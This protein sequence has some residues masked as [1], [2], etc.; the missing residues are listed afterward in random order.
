MKEKQT[1]KNKIGYSFWGIISSCVGIVIGTGIFFKSESVINSAGPL[2]S[3]VAWIL[4]SVIVVCMGMS[5]IEIASSTSKTGEVGS[6]HTWSKKFFNVKI[7]KIIGIFITFIWFPTLMVLISAIS[8]DFIMQSI[9]F[10]N[11]DIVNGTWERFAF[12]FF[13]SFSLICTMFALNIF[14]SKW[15]EKF[16]II[17]VGI[18][19]IPFFLIV[20]IGFFM[21]ISGTLSGGVKI[22]DNPK[23]IDN[24]GLQLNG[25]FLA[26]PAILF[27]FDG[28]IY[29][30]NLQNEMKDK[31]KFPKAMVVSMVIISVTYLGVSIMSVLIGPKID[32]DG[33]HIYSVPAVLDVMFGGQAWIS[34]II[35]L[36]IAISGINGING[37][38]MVSMQQLRSLSESELIC[39]KKESFQ[40]TDKKGIPKKSAFYMFIT[41]LIWFIILWTI[42]IIRYFSSDILSS[43]KYKW[44]KTI[45]LIVVANV[46]FGYF[47]YAFIILG[48]IRNRKTNKIKVDKNKWFLPVAWI[49]SIGVIFFG[50]YNIIAIFVNC[51]VSYK[52]PNFNQLGS[53]ITTIALLL[54][55]PLMF[56]LYTINEKIFAKHNNTIK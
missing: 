45:D 11:P 46:I 30:A 33:N 38:T 31:N 49:G 32:S 4:G 53:T 50:F 23:W 6:L 1:N 39:D 42:E 51:F 18:K 29:A 10:K 54:E 41:S 20:I 16:Q 24:G 22:E 40:K 5:Y 21:A 37:Y 52:D 15:G 56:A 25:I 9:E 13:I 34:I 7:A 44:F 35:L 8:S 12:I 14:K 19:F 36:I 47:I 17:G 28:F 55:I 3:I 26:I 43:E 48:A 27:S 2:L